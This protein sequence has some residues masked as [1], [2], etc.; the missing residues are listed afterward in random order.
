MNGEYPPYDDYIPFWKHQ[1]EAFDFAYDRRGTM[2]AMW[3]GT[4]K[5]RVAC[6]LLSEWGCQKVLVGCP[7]SVMGV[8]L[9][10]LRQW[11][12]RYNPIVLDKGLVKQQTQWADTA[13]KNAAGPHVF[14]QNY[15][16]LWRPPFGEWTLGQSWDCVIGD[17]SHRFGGQPPMTHICKHMMRMNKVA[18]RRLCLTG[19]PMCLNP[20]SVFG[21]CRFLEPK[22][23]GY[24]W[25][26]FKERYA[27]YGNTMIPQMITGWKNLDE[28]QTK[29]G[30]M[31][32]QAGR[33]VLD[34]P[35]A[36]HQ[37]LLF[38]LEPKTRKVYQ[39]LDD[40]L[41]SEYDDGFVSVAN[42][43]VKTLRLRQAVNGFLQLD[44]RDAVTPLHEGK[45]RVLR[46]LI[47]DVDEPIV[48]FC[49]FVPDLAMVRRA[50][51]KL[52]KRYGEISGRRTDLTEEATYPD[53]VDVLGVQYQAGGLGID[54]TKARICVIVSPPWSLDKY[55][56]AL[57]RVHRPGQTR[58]VQ[59]Y[60]IVAQNTI[61]VR[62]YK[63]LQQKRDVIESVLRPLRE[64]QSLSEVI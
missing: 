11:A 9:R 48:V 38:E 53:N 22:V 35:E 39:E 45:Y 46:D 57:A 8:W 59:F 5:T 51:E 7:V 20:L 43:L 21:Q 49:E 23:F 24:K 28:L 25:V 32:Y 33:E 31:T 41:V 62:V 50:T 26:P 64:K 54:L 37:L 4:G 10:E 44:D 14:I 30:S 61:D 36:K 34:L 3:M 15:E 29:F 52:K 63:A 16:S 40:W 55:D 2:L 47:E 58:G 1:Q 19:T 42:A 12:P 27:I 17:E 56:Q 60:S 13:L 6:E 18:R